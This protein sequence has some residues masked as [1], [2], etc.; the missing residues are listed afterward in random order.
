ML[1]PVAAT[2][3]RLRWIASLGTSPLKRSTHSPFTDGGGNV[4]LRVCLR[5]RPARLSEILDEAHCVRPGTS[6]ARCW[7]WRGGRSVKSY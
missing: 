4:A 7:S 5:L 3:P 6:W 1:S 2:L